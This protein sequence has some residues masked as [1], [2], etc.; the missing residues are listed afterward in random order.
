M[1][2]KANTVAAQTKAALQ[3]DLDRFPKR[4]HA[5]RGVHC[6]GIPAKRQEEMKTVIANSHISGVSI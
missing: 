2:S 3:V 5:S 4:Q 6:N 1:A